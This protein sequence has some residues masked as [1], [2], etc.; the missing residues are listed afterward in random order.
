MRVSFAKYEGLG[1]DF[2]IVDRLDEHGGAPPER[3]LPLSARVALCDRYR[4]V[5][6]DGVLTVLPPRT[7][8]ARARMHVTNADGSEPEMCGNGLRCVALYLVDGGRARRGEEIA[9]DTGA[10]V[11]RALV[12]EDDGVRVDMG[13]ARF[14]VDGQIPAWRDEPL[15]V[16]GLSVRAAAVSMGNPHCVVDVDKA[17][18]DLHELAARLGPVLERDPRFPQ[19][20]NVELVRLRD[21]GG[22]DVAVWE[23]GVGI[24]QA[25]GTGACGVAAVL[26]RA[27]R[28][29][30]DADV[31]VHLPGGTLVVKVPRDPAAPVWM[32]GPARRVFSGTVDA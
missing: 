3:G 15:V 25:C 27:G 2:V 32:T 24:T 21:D 13:P 23:R 10:G 9:V 31:A 5:G 19:R 8:G 18:G 6:A 1:N 12:L 14:D 4:G 7:P 30:F 11:R 17:A 26:A 28:V 16:D 22:V 20:T 29:P